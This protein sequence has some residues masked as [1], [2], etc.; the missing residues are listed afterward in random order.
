MSY[1]AFAPDAVKGGESPTASWTTPS[2]WPSR[3]C[4]P[5]SRAGA[6]RTSGTGCSGPVAAG[7]LRPPRRLRGRV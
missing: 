5:L 1:A 2:T 3:A 4:R 6:G 7:D